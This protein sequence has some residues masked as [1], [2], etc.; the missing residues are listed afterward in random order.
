[1]RICSSKHTVKHRAFLDSENGDQNTMT[2]VPFHQFSC[3]APT[4]H[5]NETATFLQSSQHGSCEKIRHH[6]RMVAAGPVRWGRLH[7]D[8]AI[9]VKLH[10]RTFQ[11][12]CGARQQFAKKYC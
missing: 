12:C 11:K 7:I 6:M 4:R 2:T 1:M 3:R 8:I 9:I 5:S 10:S